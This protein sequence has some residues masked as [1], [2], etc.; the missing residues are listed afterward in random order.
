MNPPMAAPVDV[1]DAA[2]DGRRERL[3]AGLEARA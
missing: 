1:A 3:Q 2:Q